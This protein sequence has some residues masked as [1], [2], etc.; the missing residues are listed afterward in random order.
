NETHALRVVNETH[1]DRVERRTRLLREARTIA[2]LSHPNV[3][4]VYDAG[5]YGDRVYIA[6]EFVD[7]QTV[8]QW[9]GSPRSWREI[10]DAFLAAG[11][12][13]GGARPAL[14][15]QRA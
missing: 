7:G 11:R 10:L 13:L 2:R 5:T 8:D 3:I 14:A 4:A 6:M 15:R 1:A 9:L 12:G